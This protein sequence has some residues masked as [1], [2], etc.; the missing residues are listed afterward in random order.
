MNG[1]FFNLKKVFIGKITVLFEK[2]I[3]DKKHVLFLRIDLVCFIRGV[4]GGGMI[5]F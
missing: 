4:D 3:S 5:N 1:V 2:I